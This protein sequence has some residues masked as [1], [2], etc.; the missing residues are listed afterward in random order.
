MRI[1]TALL[2]Q[3][4]VGAWSILV[5]TFPAKAAEVCG[6]SGRRVVRLA[7]HRDRAVIPGGAYCDQP[8]VVKTSDGDW[9]CV[10]TT[11]QGR[12]G[13]ATQ[14]VVSLRSTDRGESWSTPV[15]LESPGGP[16]ASYG[17]LLQVNF[18]PRLLFLQLQRAQPARGQDGDRGDVSACGFARRLCVPLH[19]RR[20][21]GRGLHSDTQCLSASSPAIEP[22][23]MAGKCAVLLERG[24]A[25][26]RG[27]GHGAACAVVRP[28]GG[29]PHA[30]QSRSDGGRVLRAV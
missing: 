20:R 23:C 18:G 27:C 28:P 12:E 17:V 16:E 10:M 15:P 7:E 29:S 26:G 4:A 2:V 22:T 3:A 21:P 19:G 8:Y 11:A 13:S 6:I 9:L 5:S 14:T 24:A 1:A 30:A 25:I